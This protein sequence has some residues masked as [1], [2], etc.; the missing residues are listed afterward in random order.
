MSSL[1]NFHL[2]VVLSVFSLVVLRVCF[3]IWKYASGKNSHRC[4]NPI[5]NTT[6][7]TASTISSWPTE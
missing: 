2:A 3:K 1:V 6:L 4:G 7:L 5:R